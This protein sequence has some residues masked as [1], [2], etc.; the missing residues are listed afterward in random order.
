MEI[1]IH[2]YLRQYIKYYLLFYWQLKQQRNIVLYPL[3]LNLIPF[4]VMVLQIIF[5]FTSVCLNIRPD[6]SPFI[7]DENR[8][9][10]IYQTLYLIALKIHAFNRPKFHLIAMLYMDLQSMFL[11]R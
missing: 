7:V 2:Y 4:G 5:V 11:Q 8:Y 3:V 1:Y 9:L 10:F 6:F